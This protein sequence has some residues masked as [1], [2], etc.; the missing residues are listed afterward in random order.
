MSEIIVALDFDSPK[1]ALELVEEIKHEIKW[2]KVGL[3]LFCL[4]GPTFI[5]ELK[6]RGLKVFLDLKFFDIP[7][8]VKGAV[9]SILKHQVDMLTLHLLGGENMFKEALKLKNIYPKCI[10]LGV[11]ILTSLDKK[12][13]VWPEK[14]SMQEIVLDLAQKGVSWG[15]EGLVCSPWEVEPIKKDFPHLVLVTPGI[16]L[17][18]SSDDQKRV[19]NPKEAV[20]K[21]SD[22]LVI[23]RPITQSQHPLKTIK[24][25][26]KQIDEGLKN[27]YSK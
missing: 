27:G 10:F 2:V 26:K 16:R 15:A 7:N 23:G 11:T 25:I 12:S 17:E 9:K 19:L 14:R 5:Q 8:T 1:K 13:L 22:F 6:K 20:Q 21:G 18:K 24:M 3:E 4:T